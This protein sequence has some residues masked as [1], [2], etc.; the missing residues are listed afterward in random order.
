MEDSNTDKRCCV[1]LAGS[2]TGYAGGD[3]HTVAIANYFTSQ[4][5]TA[6]VL[7]RNYSPQLAEI[8]D[9]SLNIVGSANKRLDVPI[10]RYSKL[11]ICYIRR[12]IFACWWAIK[13]RSTISI[14]ISGSHYLIDI[15]PIL[16]CRSANRI[17][18]W[19]HHTPSERTRSLALHFSLRAIEQLTL[20]LIKFQN[21]SVITVSSETYNWLKVRGISRVLLSEN[22]V[23][24]LQSTVGG[25]GIPSQKVTSGANLDKDLARYPMLYVGR[26]SPSKGSEDLFQII[27]QLREVFNGSFIVR[28][29]GPESYYAAELNRRLIDANLGH[30]IEWLGFV[31][32]AD[33]RFLYK[34]SKILIVPSREEGWSLVVGEALEHGCKVICYDLIAI[35]NAY[36]Q[37]N[38]QL[39]YIPVGDISA[40]VSSIC[41][42]ASGKDVTD[43]SERSVES[44]CKSW[45]E[46]VSSEFVWMIRSEV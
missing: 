38:S 2:V 16:I 45:H 29:I 31:S 6:L 36:G 7:G 10:P 21:V 37:D 26:V 28:I 24:E 18:Y 1:V 41:N 32:N 33:R 19:H 12:L 25:I 13:N 4:M 42:F 44:K 3:I 40:F 34:S 39:S 20:T 35:K 11:L 8:I 5:E 9:P 14:A 30:L 43:K 23:E 22:S 15:L 46:V 17:M 27:R